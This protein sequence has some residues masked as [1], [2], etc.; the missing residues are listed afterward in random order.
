MKSVC[1]VTAYL[2]IGRESWKTFS[3]SFEKYFSAFSILLNLCKKEKQRLV[4]YIDE[5]VG[6]KIN[7][8]N[9]ESF[10]T[11]LKI[12]KKFLNI[13]SPLWK[14]L[15]KEEE[16]MFSENFQNLIKHRNH[17]PE[18]FSPEYT[19][20]NHAKIDF[21]NYTSI[22]EP[23]DIFVWVD[24][25]FF[26][27]RYSVPDRLLDMKMINTDTINYFC[28]SEI[29][30]VDTDPYYTLKYA[31]ERVCGDCFMASREKIKEY[32]K[33]YHEEHKKLQEMNI[34]DDDQHLVLRCYFSRPDLFTLNFIE[35][36]KICFVKFQKR[37]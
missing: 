7:E 6:E 36:W 5:N 14:K 27:E 2:D 20:I 9:K 8:E 15:K 13:I 23:A 1:Y 10:V 16:I 29:K 28:L 24:F 19:L 35:R 31:P 34:V 25:G 12:N 21:L 17:C 3:R 4:V 33:L 32:A 22:F 11:F 30:S 37:D 18:T 26:S